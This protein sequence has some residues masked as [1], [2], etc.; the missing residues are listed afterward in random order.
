MDRFRL[1]FI[2]HWIW[3]AV[4]GILL[5]TGLAL[6]GPR[7][8]WA[9]NYNLAMADYL[10]RTVAI[11]FTGLLF[12]EILL[13][14]KRILFNDSKREPWLVIG[15]SG[16]ALIT[17][18]SAWLLI[19]SGLLLWHC[20]EDDHGVTALASVVHQTVTFAMIIGMTWHLYDK[21]HVLI[22]GGGRR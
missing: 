5:I 15:K 22:F 18:I 8:G 21:S 3:A 6:L 2:L 10:H 11:L 14:L 12:I 4:F 13:E 20:T 1:E 7:Y 19:I 17:F 16:F 9:L